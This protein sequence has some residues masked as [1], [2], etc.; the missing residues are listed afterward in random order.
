[1]DGNASEGVAA[2]AGG[3]LII[4][5]IIRLNSSANDTTAKP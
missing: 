4:V 2:G 1:M 3:G 5:R